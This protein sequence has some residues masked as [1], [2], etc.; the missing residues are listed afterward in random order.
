MFHVVKLGASF[1]YRTNVQPHKNTNITE[2]LF[3]KNIK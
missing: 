1:K 2:Y 3:H